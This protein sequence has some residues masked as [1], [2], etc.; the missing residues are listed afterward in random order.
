M[1]TRIAEQGNQ[2]TPMTIELYDLAGADPRLLFSPFCWRIRMALLHKGLGF[3][4]VPWRFS[5]REALAGSGFDSVPVIRDGERWVGDS[6]AIARYLDRAYPD[7][8]PLM[9]DAESEAAARFVLAVCGSLVFPAAV[10]VAVFAAHE[11]LDDAS[12][13]YF[14]ETREALFGQTLESLHAD[15]ATGRAGLAEALGPFAEVLSACDYLGGDA[16]SYA[17]YALFGILKWTD[18]VSTYRPLE[19]SGALLEWFSRLENLY[20]GYAGKVPTVRSLAAA[21]APVLAR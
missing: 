1:G 21:G 10:R 17:D 5:E 13:P 3:S 4:V 16:P 15:E 12:K 2:A 8:P 20:G 9:K 14:R 7:A 18:I 6:W 19:E 11:I